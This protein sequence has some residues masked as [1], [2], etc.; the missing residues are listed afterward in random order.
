MKNRALILAAAGK[1]SRFG[2][3]DKLLSELDGQYLFLHSLKTF[4]NSVPK[5]NIVLVVSPG[6]EEIYRKICLKE[7]RVDL[8]VIAGGAERCNSVLNGLNELQPELLVAV[9]DAARPYITK[10]LVEEA[11]QSAEEKGNTVVVKPVVDTIKIVD[12]R[13]RIRETPIRSTLRSAETPQIFPCQQL[14]SAYEQAISKGETPTDESMAV[15]AT[16]QTVYVYMHEGQN[17]KITYS[18]DLD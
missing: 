9:H 5:E 14:K 11:F 7:C 17:Q 3:A 10:D 12:D 6:Q 1:S 18:H 15:E 13:G 16:G 2:D 4:L 8:T